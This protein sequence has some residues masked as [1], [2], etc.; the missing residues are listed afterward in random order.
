MTEQTGIKE[1]PPIPTT[2]DPREFL[3]RFKQSRWHKDAYAVFFQGKRIN[4][5]VTDEER[6]EAFLESEKAKLALLDFAG[7]ELRLTYNPTH[8]PPGSQKAIGD[9]VDTV[10]NMTC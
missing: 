6:E 7:R 4:P 10:R 3:S 2:D 5:D 8:Y 1:T 9:Y